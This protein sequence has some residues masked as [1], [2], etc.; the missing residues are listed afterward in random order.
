[1]ALLWSP[2]VSPLKERRRE[3]GKPEGAKE[4]HVGTETGELGYDSVGPRPLFPRRKR[5]SGR[6][7]EK[8]RTE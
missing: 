8:R 3:R 1:M 4:R 6:G 7:S 2:T 5:E